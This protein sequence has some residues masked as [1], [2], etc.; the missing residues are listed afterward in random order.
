MSKPL[1]EASIWAAYIRSWSRVG[2][3]SQALQSWLI[4]WFSAKTGHSVS[5]LEGPQDLGGINMQRNVPRRDVDEMKDRLM[6][7][8]FKKEI[9]E[10]ELDPNLLRGSW[11]EASDLLVAH[12][13]NLSGVML[14]NQY[15]LLALYQLSIMEMQTS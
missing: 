9:R 7:D 13:G 1:V 5:S 11:T 8:V 4:K 14:A 15:K 10:K 2:I 12:Y 3:S 6:I